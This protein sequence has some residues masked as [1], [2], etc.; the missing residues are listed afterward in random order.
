MASKAV[1]GHQCTWALSGIYFITATKIPGGKTARRQHSSGVKSQKFSGGKI[2]REAKVSER[3]ISPGS[4]CPREAKVPG[5]QKSQGG[6]EAKVPGRQKSPGGKYPQEAKVPE[7]QKSWKAK[8]SE[9]QN[10]LFTG[11]AKGPRR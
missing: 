11:E 9:M 4:K 5:S 6:A 2:R 8:V 1:V 10:S 3:Q 7:R